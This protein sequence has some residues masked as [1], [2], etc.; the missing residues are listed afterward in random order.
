MVMNQSLANIRGMTLD[1]VDKLRELHQKYYPQFD[2]PEFFK[3]CFC[4]FIITDSEGEII[5]GGG[6]RTIAESMIV[7]DQSMSRI[8]IGRALIE[9]QRASMYACGRMNISE[10]HAFVDNEEYAKH[11]IKH[12]FSPRS[13]A[14]SMK[15]F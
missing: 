5:I 6:V 11:L 4:R 7:T 9:A 2:F 15:V 8:K 13:R 10:L 3:E 14:L 1:D 12:G